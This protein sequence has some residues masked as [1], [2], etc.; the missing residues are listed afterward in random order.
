M[1]LVGGISNKEVLR[2]RSRPPLLRR[3]LLRQP[4][5][6]A[7]VPGTM[8]AEGLKEA[9]CREMHGGGVQLRRHGGLQDGGAP[10]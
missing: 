2:L 6:V 10:P 3:L 5:Q 4:G 1:E 7:D 8:S 9:G